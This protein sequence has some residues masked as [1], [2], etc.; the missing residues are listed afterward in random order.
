MAKD[1]R[2][3]GEF[4]IYNLPP[5]PAGEVEFD[6]KYEIDANGI[7]EVSAEEINGRGNGYIKI[8]STSRTKTL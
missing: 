4:E 6:L 2:T 7:L 5:K 1:N 3:L 8:D